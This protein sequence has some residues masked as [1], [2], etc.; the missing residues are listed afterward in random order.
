MP[1]SIAFALA[2]LCSGKDLQTFTGKLQVFLVVISGVLLG[3]SLDFPYEHF[4]F[5]T[6][7]ALLCVI[8]QVTRISFF[9]FF[10]QTRFK[11]FEPI[12][13]I[14]AVVLFLAKNISSN[15]NIFQW[16]IPTVQ[17]TP[18][19]IFVIGLYF[20]IGG[21]VKKAKKGYGVDIGKNAP[22]FALPDMNGEIVKLSELI[23]TRN[24][25]LIFVRGDWCPW[26]HMM[27]R[28]YQ[29]NIER[30]KEKNILLLAIGPDTTEVN[31]D[32]VLKLGLE[33][34][35]RKNLSLSF[36]PLVWVFV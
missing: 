22:D 1:A 2:Y 24:L 17:L 10:A 20:D 23:G 18:T 6:L 21:L 25:L 15:E 35:L 7:S 16:I 31:R 5:F 13:W 4:P 12:V 32:M 26:C 30:F 27:L 33:L 14:S 29:K 34:H 9:T 3:V 36:I 8:A 28:T 19:G 11:Y